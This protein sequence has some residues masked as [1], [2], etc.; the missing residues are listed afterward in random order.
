MD[1]VAAD[2]V[3][4]AGKLGTRVGQPDY[5]EVGRRAPARRG[6]SSPAAPEEARQS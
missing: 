5:Q 4:G 1:D 6:F 2:V 3:P